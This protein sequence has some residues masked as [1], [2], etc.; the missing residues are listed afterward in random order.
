MTWRRIIWLVAAM[1]ENGGCVAL[2]ALALV[3]TGDPALTGW[4]NLCRAAGAEKLS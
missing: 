2:T 3:M 1:R 4:A